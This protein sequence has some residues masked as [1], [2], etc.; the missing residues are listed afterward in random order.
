[1][2]FPKSTA[3]LHTL[4]NGLK[5]ILDPSPNAPVISTQIW[6]QTGSMHEGKFLGAGISHLLE[7]MVFKGT[8]SFDSTT[9]SKAVQAAGG[10]WNAYTTFDRTVYYIDGPSEGKELFLKVLLEMVFKP[11]FPEDEFE[12]EKDV[13]RR[14]IDMGLDDPDSCFSR[15]LFETAYLNDERRHPVIGH[16]EL[17]NKL[18]HQD[19]VDYHQSRYTTENAFVSISGDFDEQEMLQFL[20]AENQTINRSFTHPVQPATELQQL[21]ARDSVSKFAVPVSKHSIAWQAPSL[22]HEDSVALDLALSILGSGRSS[23]FYK[24]IRDSRKLC[25]HVGAWSYLPANLPGLL[26]ISAELEPEKIEEFEKAVHEEIQVL[27]NDQ[28]DLE[29]EKVKRRTLVAQFSTL[30]TASGRASDSASNWFESKNLNFTSDYLKRINEVTGNDICRV[31]EKWLTRT[32]TMTFVTM[33]PDGYTPVIDS[34]SNTVKNSKRQIIEKELANGLKYKISQDSKVP[35]VS[36]SV[37]VKTGKGTESSTLAGLNMLLSSVITK[38]TASYSA[39]EIAEITESLG[40]SISSS[41]GNNTTTIS[42]SCLMPDLEKIVEILAEVIIS[43]SLPNEV[44]EQEKVIQLNEIKEGELDPASLAFK[45][46]RQNVFGKEGY[47]LPSEGTEESLK[48][49]D[50]VALQAQH[51]EYFNASNMVMSFFGDVNTEN[52]E[53]LVGTY[54]NTLKTGELLEPASQETFP[55]QQET[56]YLDKEQSVLTVGFPGCAIDSEDRY[57]LGLI[58]AW[59]SDMAGP[60][61]TKIREELGL[62]YYVSSTMFYGFDCG[63][64]TFYM[65]TSPEQLELA[66]KE[67]LGSIEAI[68]KNGMDENELANVKISYLAKQSLANQS[69]SAMASMCSLDSLLGLGANH[70]EEVAEKIKLLSVED[71]K[72]VANQYFLAVDPSIVVCS[73]EK[74]K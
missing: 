54:F 69:H 46:L 72:R 30:N 12:K 22:E 39:E 11:T 28:L 49:L 40:A 34:A 43:P 29:L 6:V 47:G 33:H 20:E 60:L 70:F 55:P 59:C 66:Q 44:I 45:K 15:Q 1:M 41:S 68:A 7:H 27:L 26:V 32:D 50:R 58:H 56:V 52:V 19:M 24:S 2:Q 51:S 48:N 67:L 14:E 5:V 10:Q 3:K 57:A 25:L 21:G 9:L 63:M 38:G 23:R 36:I 16:L 42:A 18:T 53:K 71:V 65:G 64:F 73:P 74:N 17:F 8:D 62:A 37:A 13:I 31:V 35:L 61:F 4:K